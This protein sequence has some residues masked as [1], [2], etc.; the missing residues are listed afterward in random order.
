VTIQNNAALSM[1]ITGNAYATYGYQV[2]ACDVGGCS[3]WSPVGTISVASS[4]LVPSFTYTASGLLGKFTDTSIDSAGTI[5][6]RHWVFGN[7]STS[8]LANPSNYF[9]KAGS[10]S[11]SETVTDSVGNS[12][13]YIATVTVR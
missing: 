3:A 9:P 10:Y 8:A 2:Q 11:V 12:Q 1:A 13:T 5:T 4:P 7:G 6:M